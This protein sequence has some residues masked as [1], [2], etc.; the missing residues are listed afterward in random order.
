MRLFFFLLLPVMNG[1]SGGFKME[2]Y[3]GTLEGH[4]ATKMSD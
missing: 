4:W 1:T 2:V 3:E